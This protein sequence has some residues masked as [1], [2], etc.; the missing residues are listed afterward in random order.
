MTIPKII[1]KK[2][3]TPPS[4]ALCTV[5]VGQEQNKTKHPY[6]FQYKLLYRNETGTNHHGLL[7]T[8][9]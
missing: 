3:T 2:C 4:I 9:V 8:S 1:E 7:S 6:L 5:G